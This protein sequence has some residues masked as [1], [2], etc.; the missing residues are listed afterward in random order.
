MS[1]PGKPA[2]PKS[3][4]KLKTFRYLTND[5]DFGAIRANDVYFYES[6]H[7]G[8]WVDLPNGDRRLVLAIKTDELLEEPS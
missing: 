8:F 7:V 6:G 1:F 5:G 4:Q 3:P 2:E